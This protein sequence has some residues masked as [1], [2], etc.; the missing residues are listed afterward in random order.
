MIFLHIFYSV[1]SSRRLP[2]RACICSPDVFRE[3]PETTLQAMQGQAAQLLV[4]S[5]CRP[6]SDGFPR[7]GALPFPAGDEERG[8]VTISALHIAFSKLMIVMDVL[9]EFDTQLQR[10][11]NYEDYTMAQ[12]IRQKRQ[13]VDE[14]LN[15]LLVSVVEELHCKACARLNRGKD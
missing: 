9:Q 2:R 12:T 8:L 14:A 4:Q 13:T 10:S 11:L 1:R 15:K 7:A 3:E 6:Q 5:A